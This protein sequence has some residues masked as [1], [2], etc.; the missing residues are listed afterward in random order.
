MNYKHEIAKLINIDGFSVEDIESLITFPKDSSMGDYALPCFKFAKT[1]HKAPVIIANELKDTIPSSDMIDKVDS[2]AG[3]LNFTISKVPFIKE[4]IDK[5]ATEKENY[6]SSTLGSG[7]T[8]CIDYS[9]INIAKPFHIGH[10]STTVIG[11]ALYRIYKFL[12][13]NTVGINHLGD[14]GTQFGKLIVAYK[15]WGDKQKIEND[16]IRAL[17]E[18]YVKFHTEAEKDDS[19]NDEA[20]AWFKKIEDGDTEALGL[21]EWFKDITL[22]EVSRVYKRL[23]IK[24]DSYNGESFYNDKMQP[25]LDEIE[26]KGL[27]KKSEGATIVDLEEYGMA[28]CLLKKADG[29]TLYATRDL[30]AAFYRKKTYD[31]DKCLYVV[32]YQQNLHF[33]QWFK[34]VELMGY[35]WAKDLIHVAFGMV[36]LEG[37]ALSTRKGN[38][39]FLEEVLDNAVSKAYS[40]ICEKNANLDNK[41]Q[42]AEE[43]G[44]GAVVFSALSNN[45]IKDI[46]F[47]YD[48]VL[49]FDG[50]TAPYIQYTHARCCSVLEKGNMGSE[51]DY[52]GL[53][54]EEAFELVKLLE[55]FPQIIED[56]ASKNEPSM[57]T[58]HIVSVAQAYNK[59]Y[60]NHRIIDQP[61][62]IKNARLLL[63][64]CTKDVIK[65]GL[66]LIGI[67]APTKM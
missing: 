53:N 67:K 1:L 17:L 2:V 36:S 44:V 64:A 62:G 41:E 3:Y 22:K 46:S 12:G 26:E 43:V 49:N 16:G 61:E 40:I 51:I 27:S 35:P 37:A 9:S 63:T 8:I 48:K 18:I 39:V 6:G 55:R 32:A 4:T 19:L 54:N 34:V 50:E 29:A 10:L 28:P 24:F 31:F 14:W 56:S 30:A 13:Y 58:R 20:R 52:N 7:K 38:V 65:T 60:I 57:V 5:I 59:F 33:R 47:S 23:D 42:I 21:F 66:G 11:A 15:L 45:R 25:I